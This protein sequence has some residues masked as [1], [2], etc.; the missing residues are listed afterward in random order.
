ME[1][2]LKKRGPKASTASNRMFFTFDDNTKNML[3]EISEKS[4]NFDASLPIPETVVMCI[5]YFYN[6]NIKKIL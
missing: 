4:V 1:K 2:I 6:K 3:T 5:K